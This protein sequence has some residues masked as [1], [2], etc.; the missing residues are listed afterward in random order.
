MNLSARFVAKAS[1][2]E[3]RVLVMIKI[4]GDLLRRALGRHE[5]AFCRQAFEQLDGGKRFDRVRADPACMAV[6]TI[7]GS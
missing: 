5:H 7:P 6:S 1:F 3:S 2:S 4:V